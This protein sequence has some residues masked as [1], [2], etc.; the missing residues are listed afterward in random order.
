[1]RDTGNAAHA[2]KG[3]VLSC[4]ENGICT[5]VDGTGNHYFKPGGQGS[6]TDGLHTFFLACRSWPW[7]NMYLQEGE[8][9]GENQETRKRPRRVRA[10][11][12]EEVGKAIK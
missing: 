11:L 1:M 2:Y 6:E 10:T 3:I 8:N 5:E 7:S 4:R 12:R 9:D